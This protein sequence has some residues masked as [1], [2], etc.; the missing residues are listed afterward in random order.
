VVLVCNYWTIIKSRSFSQ[1]V[2]IGAPI[3][4]S[5]AT[6]DQARLEGQ[7]VGWVWVDLGTSEHLVEEVWSQ[8][9]PN[10]S[11]DWFLVCAR[12]MK[13]GP[14]PF[15][16]WKGRKPAK[17]RLIYLYIYVFVV[18]GFEL[19]S[20]NLL[21]NCST[22]CATHLTLLVCFSDRV[23]CFGSGWPWNVSPLPLSPRRLGLQA[24]TTM[25]CHAML[26]YCCCWQYWGLN[27]G[28]WA[29]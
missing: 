23:S 3:N 17:E 26:Y 19:K 9:G 10:L 24:Y 22:T 16:V 7:I 20:S 11:R 27:P 18:L 1:L 14:W 6:E 8:D 29:C 21:G 4:S 12:I 13:E 28:T 25:P 2:K 15:Q 5:Q